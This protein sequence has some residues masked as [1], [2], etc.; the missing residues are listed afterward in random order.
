MS[1]SSSSFQHDISNPLEAPLSTA[2]RANWTNILLGFIICVAAALRLYQPNSQLWIDEV[3]ALASIQRSSWTIVTEWPGPASHIFTELL[4]HWSTLL[5]GD[6]PFAIRLPAVL[7]GVLGVVAMYPLTTLIF[8]RLHAFLATGF[9]AV[10]YHH[11]FYSQNARGYTTLIFFFLVSSYFFLRFYNNNITKKEA[12]GY[13]ASTVLASYSH[14]FG[15]FIPLSH[16]VIFSFQYGYNRTFDREAS[17]SPQKYFASICLVGAVTTLLYAPFVSSMIDHAQM[18]ASTP[19]EGPRLGLWL[20]TEVVEGLSAA[21]FG[22]IGLA[23]V[24]F[25]GLIGLIRWWRH[26]SMSVIVLTLPLI[27]QGIVFVALGF[28]IHPRYFAIA[29]PVVFITG[30]CGIIMLT[31]WSFAKLPMGTS[32]RRPLL[33]FLLGLVIVASAYP[34]MRLY[35]YPK[36]DFQGVLHFVQRQ[37]PPDAIKVGV[38]SA[39]SILGEYYDANFTRLESLDQLKTY[40]SKKEPVWV[41]TTLERTLKAGSPDLYEHIKKEYTP[42]KRFPGTIGDGTIHVYVYEQREK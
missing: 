7:F 14:P 23:T 2:L 13:I 10:S 6:T 42:I 4:A 5:F 20:V 35:Q 18:N 24:V 15:L 32:A 21:F 25:I 19:A 34:T 9:L 39:G 33:T 36:Q 41:V 1:R 30:A 27:L 16:F 11:V 3:S 22:P 28:G 37:A 38:H 12:F 40:E 8:S 17:F 26:H 31:A 29:L